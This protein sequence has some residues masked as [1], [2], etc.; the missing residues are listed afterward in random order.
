MAFILCAPLSSDITI[1][2]IASLDLLRE[3]WYEAFRLCTRGRRQSL[4]QLF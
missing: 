1:D 3:Y 4:S 2:Q